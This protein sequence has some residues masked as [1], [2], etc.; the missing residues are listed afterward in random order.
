MPDLYVRVSEVR[1]FI[2]DFDGAG[3]EGSVQQDG[4]SPRNRVLG[5]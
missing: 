2:D 4:E 5:G 1:L 3:A